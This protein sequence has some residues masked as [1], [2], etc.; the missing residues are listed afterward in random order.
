MEQ[1]A[2]L[3]LIAKIISICNGLFTTLAVLIVVVRLCVRTVLNRKQRFGWDDGLITVA[4][5]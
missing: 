3:F 4:A 5:V 1:V 2:N